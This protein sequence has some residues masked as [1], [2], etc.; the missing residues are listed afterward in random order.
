MKVLPYRLPNDDEGIIRATRSHPEGAPPLP[1]RKIPNI[2]FSHKFD[3]PETAEP[4]EVMIVGILY[5]KDPATGFFDFT[6]DPTT[7]LVAPIAGFVPVEHKGFMSGPAVMRPL[8]QGFTIPEETAITVFP[9]ST[10]AYVS[11]KFKHSQI[12][13]EVHP[14]LVYVTEADVFRLAPEGRPI[15]TMG[16]ADIMDLDFAVRQAK[17]IKE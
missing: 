16:V 9:G 11:N 15:R 10:G 12:V 4:I 8:A 7:I 5:R 14:G 17:L 1:I 13:E 2:L 6:I 3:K